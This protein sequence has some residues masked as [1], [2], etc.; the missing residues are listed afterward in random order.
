VSDFDEAWADPETRVLLDGRL[1][2]DQRR[3]AAARQR[4]VEAAETRDRKVGAATLDVGHGV[5]GL[6]RAR[7]ALEQASRGG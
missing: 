5:P 6:E 4:Q 7:K 2:P 3:R 1:A